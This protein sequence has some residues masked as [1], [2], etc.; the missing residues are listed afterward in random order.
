MD[1]LVVTPTTFFWSMSFCR[2]PLAS[3]SRERSS[4]QMDRPAAES[5]AVG[6]AL[7]MACFFLLVGRGGDGVL[8]GGGHCF[9]GDAEFLEQA[10]VVCRG[11]E[12]FEADGA[13]GVADEF[14]PAQ[15]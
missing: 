7:V 3:R 5:C 11:A 15:G 8:G 12:V 4:S 6:V 2:L 1:G 13:A 14:A 9:C 10:L